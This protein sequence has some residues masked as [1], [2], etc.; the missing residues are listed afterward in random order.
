MAGLARTQLERL[1]HRELVYGGWKQDCR[2]TVL[3]ETT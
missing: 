1:E 3:M 2:L